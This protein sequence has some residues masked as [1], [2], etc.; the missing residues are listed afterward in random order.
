MAF[1]SANLYHKVWYSN[2]FSARISKIAKGDNQI[3][4][5]TR[6]SYGRAKQVAHRRPRHFQVGCLAQPTATG[7]TAPRR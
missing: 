2:G 3:G 1:E 5:N 6:R 4:A 7:M